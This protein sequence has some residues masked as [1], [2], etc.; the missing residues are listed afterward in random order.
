MRPRIPPVAAA[1][2]SRRVVRAF[3]ALA[4]TFTFGGTAISAAEPVRILI[5]EGQ[6]HHQWEKTSPLM[7]KLFT[8]SGRFQVTMSRTPPAFRQPPKAPAKPADEA[9]QGT[10]AEEL[11]LYVEEKAAWDQ[12]QRAAWDAWRPALR[13]YD[14]VLSNY[15]G[16]E[17]PQPVREDF[18][19]YVKEG[20]GFVCVD[21]ASEV[22]ADWPEYNT[23]T[24]LG[25]FGG[26]TE[27][28]GPMMRLRNGTWTRDETPGRGG[29]HGMK[30]EYVIDVR[31]AEH[32]IMAGLPPQWKH[33]ADTL[34]GTM[35]GPAEHMTILA[36]AYS[37]PVGKGTSE[38]E[39]LMMAVHFG[40]GRV[41]NTLIGH[42]PEA[43]QGVGFQITLLRGSEWAATGKVTILP[44]ARGTLS[45]DMVSLNPVE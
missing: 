23:M 1:V 35:R 13:Q 7:A 17:W 4:I 19:A 2:I 45:A 16:Q 8:A 11:R 5:I 33:A 25:G 18:V 14:V 39:P 42:S 26:R 29:S 28:N 34:Y 38:H 24:G 15:N 21:S 37:S 12:K 41:F 44:D 10:Y 43:M 27:K 9:R 6:N 40:K 22:F 36:S 20:G 32:P 30:H 3:A 31:A